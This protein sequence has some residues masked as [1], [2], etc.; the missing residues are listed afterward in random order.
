VQPPKEEAPPSAPSLNE[1]M[2][3]GR[4]MQMQYLTSLQSI[5]A[6]AWKADGNKS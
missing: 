6:D 1:M 2:G 5:F 4:E 3:K